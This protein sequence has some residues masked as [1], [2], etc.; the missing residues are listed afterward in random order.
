MR[1][2]NGFEISTDDL[3]GRKNREDEEGEAPET[4]VMPESPLAIL[5]AVGMGLVTLAVGLF[6]L[7]HPEIENGAFVGWLGTVIGAVCL[8]LTFPL[9]LYRVRVDEA[10]PRIGYGFI[11]TM[12][13][14]WNDVSSVKVIRIDG[15]GR[16]RRI[17]PYWKWDSTGE[18]G[19]LF[20]GTHTMKG[21]TYLVRTAARLELPCEVVTSF[22]LKEICS[23]AGELFPTK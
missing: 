20:H 5:E 17:K 9:A 23:R 1:L 16:E 2:K 10:G 13:I 12:T 11:T 4:F 14:L 21:F 6:F 15:I 3:I 19:C 7:S 18:K 22:P 8:L